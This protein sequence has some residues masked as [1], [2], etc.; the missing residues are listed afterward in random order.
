MQERIKTLGPLS[1]AKSQK[2]HGPRE[3]RTTNEA[4]SHLH[5]ERVEDG[6]RPHL[7]RL[8]LRKHEGLPCAD[9]LPFHIHPEQLVRNC[10]MHI[11]VYSVVLTS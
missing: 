8:F 11:L 3:N 1:G 5:D 9:H 6:E 2:R 10:A 7:I 4:R